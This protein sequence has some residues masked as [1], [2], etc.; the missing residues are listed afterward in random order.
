[1]GNHLGDALDYSEA[2]DL[3]LCKAA[4]EQE[5]EQ[6]G[7]ESRRRGIVVLFVL[8]FAPVFC[9]ILAPLF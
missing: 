5:A 8:F 6:A 4:F 3:V 9:C 1:M 2:Y 7:N